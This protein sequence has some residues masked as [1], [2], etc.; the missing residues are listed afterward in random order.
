[1]TS[2]LL[3]EREMRIARDVLHIKVIRCGGSFVCERL[4]IERDGTKSI[5]CVSF[6]TMDPL[7]RFMESDPFYKNCR[8]EID[9]LVGTMKKI[10]DG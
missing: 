5:Q 9:A 4:L 7:H 2:E 1:M 10:I 6:R 3:V 8:K